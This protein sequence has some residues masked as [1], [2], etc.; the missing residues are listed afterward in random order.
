MYYW[1]RFRGKADWPCDERISGS[2]AVR[3]CSLPVPRGF[4]SCGAQFCRAQGHAEGT[5]GRVWKLLHVRQNAAFPP[6]PTGK[7]RKFGVVRKGCP[8]FGGK[9]GNLDKPVNLKWSGL[10]VKSRA[11]LCSLTS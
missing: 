6:V 10:K 9:S 5:Q 4:Q 3:A 11:K 2:D 7:R 8:P 1:R